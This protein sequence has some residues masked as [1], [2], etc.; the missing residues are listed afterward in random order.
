MRMARVSTLTPIVGLVLY[1]I[2][3]S[4]ATIA[5]ITYHKAIRSSISY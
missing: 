5:I 2:G 3:I 4:L 1:N